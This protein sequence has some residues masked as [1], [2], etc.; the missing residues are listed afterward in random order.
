MT[1]SPATSVEGDTS[2]YPSRV[3]IAAC[4]AE[5][6]ADQNWSVN[7]AGGDVPFGT[8]FQAS[9]PTAGPWIMFALSLRAGTYSL[10]LVSFTYDG[11]GIVSFSLDRLG[12]TLTDI[13]AAPYNASNADA[14]TYSAAPVS[15]AE[16]VVCSDL[17]IP[18]DADY[19]VRATITAKNPAS[20]GFVSNLNALIFH[21][22]TA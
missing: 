10:T 4:G 16:I 1:L 13:D 14:D 6:S 17:V 7:P 12:S 3:F 8:R 21:R 9:A 20:S 11:G 15:N 2:D 19:S 22:L 18:A 5:N